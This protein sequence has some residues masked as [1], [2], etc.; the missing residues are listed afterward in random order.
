MSGARQAVLALA[1]AGVTVRT[2]SI[3]LG[4]HPTVVVAWA[5]GHEPSAQGLAALRQLVDRLLAS[6]LAGD[7][8]ADARQGLALQRAREALT[9]EDE[10]RELALLA[11]A[12]AR[13]I[14]RANRSY[15]P[16]ATH[17]DPFGL[18]RADNDLDDRLDAAFG[19]IAA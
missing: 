3:E 13:T 17:V 9:T 15:V 2:L 7:S 1:D 8:I 11:D 6:V 12:I 18:C 4:V 16:V 10:R 19:P 5:A 14:E